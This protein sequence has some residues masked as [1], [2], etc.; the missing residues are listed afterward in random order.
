MQSYPLQASSKWTSLIGHA[1]R[2]GSCVFLSSWFIR[3]GTVDENHRIQLPAECGITTRHTSLQHLISQLGVR[4]KLAGV[5]HWLVDRDLGEAGSCGVLIMRVCKFA[6]VSAYRK[7]FGAPPN[8]QGA[9]GCEV[10]SKGFSTLLTG[11]DTER[12]KGSREGTVANSRNPTAWTWRCWQELRRS[13]GVEGQKTVTRASPSTPENPGKWTTQLHKSIV[14][15]SN[16]P[17]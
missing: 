15:G 6:I 4:S 16:R 9:T 8:A 12:R 5:W 3:Q 10:A 13:R 2:A 1:G 17:I 14:V 7:D 11:P